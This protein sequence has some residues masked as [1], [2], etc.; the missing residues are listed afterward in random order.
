VE[1]AEEISVGEVAG[2]KGRMGR[3]V[4]ENVKV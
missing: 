4:V 3:G 1:R 2:S